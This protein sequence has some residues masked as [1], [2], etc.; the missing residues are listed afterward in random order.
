MCICWLFCRYP[1]GYA[2]RCIVVTRAKQGH[3]GGSNCNIWVA[4]AFAL[5]LPPSG[6]RHLVLATSWW[7]A[8]R[9]APL[10][11]SAILPMFP[12]KRGKDSRLAPLA[13][14]SPAKRGKVPQ[15]DGGALARTKY[16]PTQNTKG[17]ESAPFALAMVLFGSCLLYASDAAD[18]R[19]S[20]DLGGRRII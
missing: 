7:L 1:R 18:E 9:A 4:Q 19:S 6:C 14:P 5:K 20:V 2:E 8:L 12:R 17:A 15:A 11:T 3:A 16:A 13:F 10:Q